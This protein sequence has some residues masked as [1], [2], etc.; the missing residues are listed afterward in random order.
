[1]D[2]D[3]VVCA[4][5]EMVVYGNALRYLEH[6]NPESDDA[7]PAFSPPRRVRPEAPLLSGEKTAVCIRTPHRFSDLVKR[8]YQDYRHNGRRSLDRVERAVNHLELFFGDYRASEIT[9]EAIERYIGRRLDR[10]GVA[11]AGVNYELAMLKR[12]FTLS[13]KLLPF[14]PHFPRLHLNNVRTGFFEESEF[15]AFL[16]NIDEN[17][18]PVMEL[19]YITGWRIRSEIL[20]L[21]WGL[22]VDLGAG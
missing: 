12:M 7:V 16:A 2:L 15:R 10:F 6:V 3:L 17:L 20:P 9:D 8:L 14:R 11:K 18:Q 5:P 21:R 13:R 4:I 22:N 19:A 1:M